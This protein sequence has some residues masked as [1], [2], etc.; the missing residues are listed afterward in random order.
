MERD[1]TITVIGI[2]W[3]LQSLNTYAPLIQHDFGHR[4]IPLFGNFAHLYKLLKKINISVV[5]G[6]LVDFGTSQMQISERPGFSIYKDMPLDM[7]M[8]LSHQKETAADIINTASPQLLADIFY[9]YGEERY[10]RKIAAAIVY[11]RVKKPFT[12]TKQLADLI[13]RIVPWPKHI[14]IHPA[15]RV[16]QA[17]RIYV[18][19]ELENIT[20]FLKGVP[21]LL[22]HEG[23]LVCI[24]FHSLEDRMIKQF[25]KE[26]ADEGVFKIMT[27]KVITATQEEVRRNPSSR[28]AKLRAAARIRP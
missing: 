17:L 1:P 27:K 28:S 2:D 5:N 13:T 19:Q 25:F 24:S 8:S 23:R 26:K 10:S 7:R 15:T 11:D 16:F 18:N 4:F 12:T 22:A 14:K 6:I 3:D 21:D 20:A 9:T